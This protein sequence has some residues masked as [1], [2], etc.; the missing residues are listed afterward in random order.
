VLANSRLDSGVPISVSILYQL[1]ETLTIASFLFYS[2]KRDISVPVTFCTLVDDDS[3]GFGFFPCTD[4][5]PN[6]LPPAS[7]D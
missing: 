4:R 3:R 5:L 2:D 7:G 6:N 1:F